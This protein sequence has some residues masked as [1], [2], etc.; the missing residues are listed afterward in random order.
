MIK[1]I[2][3]LSCLLTIL[4]GSLAVLGA[5]IASAYPAS[6]DSATATCLSSSHTEGVY[7]DGNP[8]SRRWGWA[9]TVHSVGCN[10]W[11][12][13]AL[14][15]KLP[16]GYQVNV[17]LTRYNN[18]AEFDHRYCYVEAGGANCHTPAILTTACQWSYRTQAI[19]YHWNG[20]KWDPVA[21]NS[22][23]IVTYTCTEDPLR[24]S[25]DSGLS[26]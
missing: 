22:A 26:R 16:S 12:N 25:N 1:R 4:G 9:T 2:L 11:G 10:H 7:T 18:R 6:A 5:S 23:G 8:N 13:V 19:I 20:T 14:H 21:W 17:T 24:H 3:R 15:E